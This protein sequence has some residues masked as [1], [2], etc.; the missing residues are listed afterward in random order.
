MRWWD[1]GWRAGATGINRGHRADTMSL[2]NA[3]DKTGIGGL[4]LVAVCCLRIGVVFSLLAAMGLGFLTGDTFL[5]P[6]MGIL[7]AV[8][9]TGLALDYR[10]HRRAMLLTIAAPGA[11]ALYFFVFIHRVNLAVY[12]AL[13]GLILARILNLIFTRRATRRTT[14]GKGQAGSGIELRQGQNSG[15][16]RRKLSGTGPLSPVHK[17]LS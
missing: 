9:L 1:C 4:F 13:S 7:L 16:S 2:K 15:G 10:I 14:G 6:A 12:A 5:M 3:L 11:T 8:I 17:N